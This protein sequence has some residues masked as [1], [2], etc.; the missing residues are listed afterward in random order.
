MNDKPVPG[1]RELGEADP[2]GD[3]YNCPRESL[4]LSSLTDDQ[5]A[6]AVFLHG[7]TVPNIGDVIAGRAKMPIVYL[8]AAK[9]RIRWLSRRLHEAEAEVQRLRAAQEAL[10]PFA[11][12]N[13]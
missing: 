8:T 3:S 5:L 10:S 6:N 9:D 2:H 7:N 4:T 12:I 11:T 1:W 13:S